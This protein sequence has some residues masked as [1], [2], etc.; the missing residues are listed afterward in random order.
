MSVYIQGI[1]ILGMISVIEVTGMTILTGFT[2]IFSLGHA[3]FIACG[4]YTAAILTKN[5]GVNFYIAI[6]AGALLAGILSFIIGI[7]TFRA[8]L[9]SDYFAIATLGFGEAFRVI[10][11]HLSITQ[12][13]RGLPGIAQ[14]SNFWNVLIITVLT[15][16]VAR[17]FI[18]SKYG[19]RAIALREDMTAA[20]MMG[21]DVYKTQMLSLFISATMA[22]LGGGL[23]AHYIGF[24][25]PSMFTQMQSSMLIISVVAGGIGSITGPVIA[26]MLFTSIPEVLRVANLWR[27]VVYGAVLVAVMVL[28]PQGIMGFRE[29]RLPRFLRKNESGFNHG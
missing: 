27:M 20:E 16:L 1:L 14:H 23:F 26:A 7:P 25:Q 29:L 10:L 6:T 11:E 8:K 2:G 21:I 28:R 22:G 4:A 24:I 3:S 9:K 17:N 19:R 12:G 5:F 18:F 13:A 15:I